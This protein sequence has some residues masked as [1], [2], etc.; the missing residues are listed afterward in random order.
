MN[1]IDYNI[2]QP[3]SAE[4]DMMRDVEEIYAAVGAETDEEQ[5]VVDDFLNSDCCNAEDC[6]TCEGNDMEIFVNA[7]ICGSGTGLYWGDDDSMEHYESELYTLHHNAKD[8]VNAYLLTNSGIRESYIARIEFALKVLTNIT[9]VYTPVYP[10]DCRILLAEEMLSLLKSYRPDTPPAQVPSNTK[11]AGGRPKKQDD[12]TIPFFKEIDPK[13]ADK[14]IEYLLKKKYIQGVDWKR[15]ESHLK[16]KEQ[17]TSPVIWNETNRDCARIITA[18]SKGK[19]EWSTVSKVFGF[20]SPKSLASEV[21]R[22]PFDKEEL[23]K[24]RKDVLR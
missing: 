4:Y 13:Y 12:G 24:T 10:I 21:S 16:K 9:K 17:L 23:D 14:I 7:L 20:K 2:P 18:M 19:P 8:F 15:L 22:K 6:T 5:L 3:G 1:S 11:H